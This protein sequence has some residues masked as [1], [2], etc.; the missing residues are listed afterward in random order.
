MNAEAMT[1]R[2]LIPLLCYAAFGAV[3][4]AWGTMCYAFAPNRELLWPVSLPKDGR[5]AM[6]VEER[7][8]FSAN[9]FSQYS[10]SA[11][12]ALVAHAIL[13]RSLPERESTVQESPEEVKVW[14]NEGVGSQYMALA[15]ID[16][17][18]KRVD[19]KDVT[20]GFFDKSELSVTLPTIPPGTYAVRYRVQS[21]DGHIVS[22]KYSFSVEPE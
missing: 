22:G 3:A 18:G 9:P 8:L 17:E 7:S 19:N 10:S 21:A 15:V 2:L 6:G 1:K 14:F 11:K 20:Q 13:V 5:V 16:S 4:I 12:G